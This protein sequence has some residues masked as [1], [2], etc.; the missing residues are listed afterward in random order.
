MKN[1]SI[2]ITMS[3]EQYQQC[4]KA[5]LKKGQSVEEYYEA[6]INNDRN[7]IVP[8]W[9]KWILPMICTTTIIILEIIF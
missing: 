8:K 2:N 4:E 9:L 5:A 1:F 3:N 7:E 6:F